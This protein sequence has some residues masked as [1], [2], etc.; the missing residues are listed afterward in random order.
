MAA[1]RGSKITC[2]A[3]TETQGQRL[4]VQ[5][6]L[7]CGAFPRDPVSADAAAHRRERHDDIAKVLTY[8]QAAEPARGDRCAGAVGCRRRAWL[9]RGRT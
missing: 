1:G 2:T 4:R 8:D 7:G 6:A 9:G 3:A 5:G